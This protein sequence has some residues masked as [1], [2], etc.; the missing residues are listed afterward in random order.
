[1]PFGFYRLSHVAAH[2]QPFFKEDIISGCKRPAI[3]LPLQSILKEIFLILVA[4]TN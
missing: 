1:M 3:S 4:Y 2:L